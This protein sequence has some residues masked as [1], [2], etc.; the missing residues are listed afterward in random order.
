[1]CN[2]AVGFKCCRRGHFWNS[3]DLLLCTARNINCSYGIRQL[4]TVCTRAHHGMNPVH[5]LISCL[6]NIHLNITSPFM[7]PISHTPSDC[8]TIFCVSQCSVFR[9]QQPARYLFNKHPLPNTAKQLRF[10]L[11][12]DSI[13]GIPFTDPA[14]ELHCFVPL[15]GIR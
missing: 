6:S 9:T 15:A 8:Q 4:I 7:L 10:K 1:V 14:Q 11:S 13:S 12:T 2:D 3:V 5:T